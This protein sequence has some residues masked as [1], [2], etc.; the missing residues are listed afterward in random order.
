MTLEAKV[1][2]VTG[3]QRGLGSVASAAM[4]T[5]HPEGALPAALALFAELNQ[6]AIRYCHWKS[7]VRLAEALAGRTDLDLLVDPQHSQRFQAILEGH[8]VKRTVA[9]PGKRYPDI[10]NY[11]GFDRQS[12]RQFHLHVHYRL[13]LG[14]QFVKNYRLPLEEMFLDSAEVHQGVKIPIPVLE[15]VVLSMR[16]LLKYRD[17]DALKDALNIRRPG[18]PRDILVEL[19]YLQ[20]QVLPAELQRTLADLSGVLPT[21]AIQAFLQT[22][23]SAPR[24]GRRFYEQRRQVRRGLRPYQRH[25]RL[26]ATLAYYGELRRRR[27]RFRLFAQD[28]KMK[29][30]TGGIAVAMIGADGSGKSTMSQIMLEWL[31][32][33]LS[34]RRYYLGSKEPSRR[35]RAL[36]LMFR[37]ARRSHRA[38][39]GKLG[40]ANPLA[41]LAG[42]TSQWLFDAHSLSL[43]HDRRRIYRAGLR[44]AAAGSVVLFD[45]YPLLAPLDGPR[46]GR[47]NNGSP[48][49]IQR[50]LAGNEEHVYGAIQ[51]PAHFLVLRVSPAVSLARKPDHEP[52]AIE[53][54]C[55]AIDQFLAGHFPP[56]YWSGQDNNASITTIDADQPFKSVELALKQALWAV[57]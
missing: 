13:V 25:G 19:N 4:A 52:A 1:A 31:S 5:P 22:V 30:S 50:A 12:G 6:A 42:R 39:A 10:E 23:A 26:R 41:R 20:S 36:Y 56:G 21:A 45:R 54:K 51:P 9:A 40:K 38:V 11:L 57:I 55:R 43:G 3:E 33:K 14:E 28:D 15:L 47:S 2:P 34:A 8:Q 48:D 49:A 27:K 7:N 53:A 46:I 17:R 24:D 44:D 37:A 18:L 16:A 32:W 29:P 35:S